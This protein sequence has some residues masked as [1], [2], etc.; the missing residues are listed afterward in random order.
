MFVVC[1]CIDAD[2][3]SKIGLEATV[4]NTSADQPDENA[5]DNH[6]DDDDMT[7]DWAC[8]SGNIQCTE[9]HPRVFSNRR[10]STNVL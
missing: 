5:K 2:I 6:D 10:E 1:C 4:V 8:T 3:S 7:F 9:S